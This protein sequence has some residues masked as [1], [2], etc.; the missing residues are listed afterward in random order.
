[1]RNWADKPER[2]QIFFIHSVYSLLAEY[3][4]HWG[5]NLC[6]AMPEASNYIAVELSCS[7]SSHSK[8]PPETRE[9]KWSPAGEEG[10]K[11]NKY[12]KVDFQNENKSGSE[13]HETVETNPQQALPIIKKKKKE[14]R[15]K[16][17]LSLAA[18]ETSSKP[19]SS[20]ITSCIFRR[21]AYLSII[22]IPYS[23]S[24]QSP[25]GKKE[26]NLTFKSKLNSS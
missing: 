24:E 1:M 9:P 21:W 7:L 25:H 16:E 26:N 15:R 14:R 4:A 5:L 11:R 6:N 20:W 19:I 17:L 2:S 23:L 18:V 10:W 12:C 8:V 22:N 3:R 13:I